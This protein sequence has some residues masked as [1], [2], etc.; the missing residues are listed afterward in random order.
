MHLPKPTE[1]GDFTPAPAGTFV[2]I[3]YRFL[4][5][6]THMNEYNG[7]RKTRHEV[8]ISWEIP[9]EKMDDGRP[10]TINKRYTWS[11]HEK[12]TL[13]QH[14]EA[15]RKKPFT[16][17]DFEG[18]HAFD[19]RNILG[20]PCTLTI[21]QD[22]KPDGKI[23]SKV[24]SVGP[25]M[26]GVQTPQAV[27]VPVYLA[28]TLDRWDA[29]VYAELGDYFKTLILQSPEYKDLMQ[30]LR[31][32]DDPGTGDEAFGAPDYSDNIPF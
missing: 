32:P 24:A 9:D 28:L 17:K 25:M 31:K 22:R 18:P 20:K 29:G 13:R 2:A 1:G 10:I 7:E 11:M 16:D 8:L 19:T 15:W 6:G 30:K 26:K 3:C 14:L 12:S 4:D 23:I 27:N 21:T 5:L